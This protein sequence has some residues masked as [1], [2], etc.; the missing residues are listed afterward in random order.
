MT[1][2][3]AFI[4]AQGALSLGEVAHIARMA[5]PSICYLLGWKQCLQ[6]LD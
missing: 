5:V 6:G 3:C 2:N 1:P 4:Q